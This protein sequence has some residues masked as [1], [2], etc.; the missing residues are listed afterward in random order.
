M[1]Q[2]VAEESRERKEENIKEA[3]EREKKE[4]QEVK[5][6]FLSLNVMNKSVLFSLNF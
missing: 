3:E 1:V 4:R 5:Q 2:R 6:N